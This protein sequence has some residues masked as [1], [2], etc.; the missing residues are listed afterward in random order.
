VLLNDVKKIAILGVLATALAG[1][2]SYY[3]WI[4]VQREREGAFQTEMGR[5]LAAHSAHHE[6][7]S[8]QILRAL[9]PDVEKRWPTGPQLIA[10]LS[11]LGTIE[12]VE[13]K[14]DQATPVLQRAIELAEAQGASSTTAVGRAKMN[15]GIIARD[16]LDDVAAER[17]FTEAAAILTKEAGR[18]WGDADASLLNLGYLA[19]KDGRY[20]DAVSY[21]KRSIAGYESIFSNRPEPDLA[22]A[23][24]RLG[25]VYSHLQDF[26]AAADQYQAAWKMYEQLEGP[27]GRDAN[28]ALSELAIVQHGERSASGNQNLAER[29][30]PLPE[31]VPDSDGLTLNNLA[32]L[33]EQRKQYAEAESLFQ[34]SC[35]AYE[36]SGG[37][38]DAGLAAV[39]ENLGNLYRDQ[40]QFDITKAEA[41]LKRA[42]DIRERVLGPEHPETAKTL[43]DLSL[44][45]FYEKNSGAAEEFARRALPLQEKVYGTDSLPVSTTLNRLGISERDQGKFKEAEANLQRALTIRE[46]KHAPSKWIIISLENLASVYTMQGQNSQAQ[47]LMARAQVIRS[48]S[49]DN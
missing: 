35:Q 37:P 11:W 1:V 29:S 44:L 18:G 12:R 10:T 49:S 42:L 7:E 5:A 41:P 21:L 47:S 22:N 48:H 16:E 27:Q 6:A 26:P 19:D 14:Y 8:E 40:P 9:L 4:W 25:D 31:N 13:D 23:H 34:R 46:Q 45:Y 17:L 32:T 38:N 28:I 15:L 33:A 24:S 20:Q 39:L 36:K 2:A 43:S 3:T 30:L